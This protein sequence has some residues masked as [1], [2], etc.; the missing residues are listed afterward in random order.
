MKHPFVFVIPLLFSALLWLSFRPFPVNKIQIN[1]DFI[2]FYK[3]AFHPPS[4]HSKTYQHITT[5]T[6]KT[7][8]VLV[9]PPVHL[10]SVGEEKLRASLNTLEIFPSN[11]LTACNAIHKRLLQSTVSNKI[12]RI[13]TSTRLN[14][15]ETKSERRKQK[16]IQR[17][18]TYLSIDKTP[19]ELI[20]YG[21]SELE[22][23]R[24]KLSILENQIISSGQALSLED[25]NKTQTHIFNDDTAIHDAYTQRR[26]I[27]A[28]H[29][30]QLF[31][32]YD[33]SKTSII[34]NHKT[35]RWH[36]L[37]TYQ[38]STFTYYWNGKT[39]SGKELDFLMLHELI[40]GHHLQYQVSK[41]YPLCAPIVKASR[42]GASPFSEGW[43]TYVESLG[44]E[45]GLFQSFEQQLGHLDY[46]LVRAIR[47]ILDVHINYNG[48]N[49]QRMAL[50]WQEHMPERLQE[51]SIIDREFA[52]INKMPMQAMT[53][54]IGADFIHGL[55]KS[56]E[57]RLGDQFD[58]KEFHDTLLRLGPVP[59]N[60]LDEIF[61]HAR[62]VK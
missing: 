16:Y 1:A 54:N 40:P 48:W 6:G 24:L 57:Q 10:K 52:R 3:T 34:G 36:A 49:K 31:I 55:R 42:S 15:A 51:Q 7:K 58:I 23:A 12:T 19:E 43:A 30:P 47:I 21:Y 26:T 38:N 13:N 50:F 60:T 11:A 62:Q 56:E 33:I 37:G 5:A 41:K 59:L 29:Y 2:T 53:Y 9:P 18:Q 46:N 4:S 27:I 39:Y 32:P 14:E 28:A 35:N 22:A 44:Q 45:L 8:W 17:I 61:V 25:F 20:Q